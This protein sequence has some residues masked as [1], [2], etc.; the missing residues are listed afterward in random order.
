MADVRDGAVILHEG[1][2][3]GIDP[4]LTPLRRFKV[5]EQRWLENFTQNQAGIGMAPEDLVQDGWTDL[6]KRIR[7]PILQLPADQRNP[8]GMLAAYEDA[9][10]EKMEEIRQ[11]AEAVVRDA[12]TAEKLDKLQAIALEAEAREPA[13][14]G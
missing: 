11:R 14:A 4:D 5:D 12:E 9:D 7:N 1:P 8:M 2:G 3:L 13:L 10:H 6:A